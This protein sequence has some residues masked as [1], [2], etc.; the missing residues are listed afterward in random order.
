MIGENTEAFRLKFSQQEQS[1][2]WNL[3][4]KTLEKT[5]KPMEKLME[6]CEKSVWFLQNI[7]EP[8]QNESA[9]QANV[10]KP[11]PQTIDLEP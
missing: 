2:D 10:V 1:I 8:Q 6:T 11:M 9:S 7:G 5:R 4:K 3:E